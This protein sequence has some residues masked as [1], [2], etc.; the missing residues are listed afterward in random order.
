MAQ[1]LL[2][3]QSLLAV[4]VGQVLEMEVVELCVELLLLRVSSLV[5][6][7]NKILSSGLD[8]PLSTCMVVEPWTACQLGPLDHVMQ[9]LMTG[10]AAPQHLLS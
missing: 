5:G 10:L 6:V 9:N 8:T 4:V 1:G 2:V 7:T 3:A